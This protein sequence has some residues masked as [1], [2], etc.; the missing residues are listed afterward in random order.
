MQIA[1]TQKSYIRRIIK[2]ITECKNNGMDIEYNESN[3]TKILCYMN[4]P[5]DSE[6]EGGIFKL[7]IEFGED[8]PFRAP[9]INFINK[10]YHPNIS[11]GGRICLDILSDKWSP[12]LS[13]Y[14]LLL[15]I[16]SLLTDP[17]P[18]SPLNSDAARLYTKDK[19]EYHKQ[20]QTIINE[21]AMSI[22]NIIIK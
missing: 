2:D 5:P 12:A 7:S 22:D 11:T 8:F 1:N 14:N 16:Q 17:N 4:G 6:Y 20:C 18:D 19:R 9:Q 21:H 13:L 3:Y 15:S 10:I